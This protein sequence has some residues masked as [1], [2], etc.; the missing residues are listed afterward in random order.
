MAKETGKLDRVILEARRNAES[1][2]RVIASRR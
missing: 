2:P 1:A